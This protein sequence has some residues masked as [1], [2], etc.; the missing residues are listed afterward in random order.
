MVVDSINACIER[1]REIIADFPLALLAVQIPICTDKNQPAHQR[2][3][4]KQRSQTVN[5]FAADCANVSLKTPS[6]LLQN[7][8]SIRRQLEVKMAT[9]RSSRPS[10][11]DRAFCHSAPSVWNSLPLSVISDLLLSLAT[12]KRQLKTALYGRLHLFPTRLT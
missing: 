10:F 7:V 4:L 9:T 6:G 5:I 12:F 2:R 11:T 8:S 3:T 1:Y